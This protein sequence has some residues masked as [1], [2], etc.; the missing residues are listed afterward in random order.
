MSLA[1]VTPPQIGTKLNESNLHNSN[2]S[3]KEQIDNFF[4]SKLGLFSITTKDNNV[5][6]YACAESIK[7]AHNEY[8]VPQ[9]KRMFYMDCNESETQVRVYNSG[10]LLTIT[11][12]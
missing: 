3:A 11:M 1:T 4:V 6:D 2:F 9:K 5:F 10:K 8:N 12:N 7:I